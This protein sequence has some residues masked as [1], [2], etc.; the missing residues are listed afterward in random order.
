MQW[1]TGQ[2]TVTFPC[3]FKSNVY[4]GI[5]CMGVPAACVPYTKD[6]TTTTMYVAGFWSAV[7]TNHR[8]SWIV[9]GS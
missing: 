4:Q 8:I 7:Y 2:G 9:L 1:G 3:S 5:A 6:Y